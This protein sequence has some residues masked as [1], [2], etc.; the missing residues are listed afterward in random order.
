MQILQGERKK[1][2]KR[3]NKRIWAQQNFSPS[4]SNITAHRQK[5]EIHIYIYQYKTDKQ[6]MKQN[7]MPL[8]HKPPSLGNSWCQ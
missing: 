2:P 4:L 1:L 8:K 7:K 5:G 3:L 6:R